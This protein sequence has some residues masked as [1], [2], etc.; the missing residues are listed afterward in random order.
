[1]LE[2]ETNGCLTETN[3]AESNNNGETKNEDDNMK[4]CKVSN[5]DDAKSDSTVKSVKDPEEV[6]VKSED[7]I[8]SDDENKVNLFPDDDVTLRTDL[9]VKVDKKVNDNSSKSKG[10][11]GA[12]VKGAK[13]SKHTDS[14]EDYED[15]ESNTEAA[16]KSVKTNQTNEIKP[17]KR[18]ARNEAKAERVRRNTKNSLASESGDKPAQSSNRVEGAKSNET[19]SRSKRI[20]KDNSVDETEEDEYD[21]DDEPRASKRV[22]LQYQPFQSPETLNII[23]PAIYKQ[24]PAKGQ[25]GKIVL[26]NKGDFLAV[27]NE[28]G[29]FFVCRTAQNVYKS[30]RKFKIQWLSD[31]KDPNVYL[32]DFYDTTDFE[33]VLTNLKMTRLDRGKFRLPPEERKR[34][35]NILERA[36]NVEKG[37]SEKPDPRNVVMD[38]VDFSI[39]GEEEE[40]EL[41]QTVPQ[42]KEVKDKPTKVKQKTEKLK[43]K[44]EVE[45]PPKPK[46]EKK[47]KEVPRDERRSTRSS[48]AAEPDVKVELKSPRRRRSEAKETRTEAPVENRFE[49][50]SEGRSSKADKS[51]R[52]A[53]LKSVSDHKR[54]KI[55]ISLI[56]N[57]KVT[58]IERD[59]MFDSKEDVTPVSSYVD[60]KV[61]IRAVNRKD[62]ELIDKLASEKR[63]SCFCV[64][65]SV[66]VTR[67]AFS[68]ALQKQDLSAL[69]ILTD[70]KYLSSMV[71]LPNVLISKG[72]GQKKHLVVCGQVNK[73]A[74]QAL[75]AL[76]TDLCPR[77]C[78]YRVLRQRAFFN[79]GL[80][81]QCLKYGMSEQNLEK[82]TEL[83]V[84][85]KSNIPILLC[86]N[87]A[88]AIKYGHRETARYLV[89]KALKSGGYGFTLLHADLLGDDTLTSTGDVNFKACSNHGIAPIHCAAINPD[90]YFLS[91]C[92]GH[93]GDLSLVDGEGWSPL[94][95]AAV[96]SGKRPL[97]YLLNHNCSTFQRD[98]RHNTP[99]HLAVSRGRIGNV[100]LILSHEANGEGTSC[101][102]K[103]NK[104]GYTPLHLACEGGHAEIVSILL[105]SGADGEKPTSSG[106]YL[107]PLMVAARG[108]HLPVVKMLIEKGVGIEFIDVYERTALLHA[109]MNGCS[110]VVSY[111]LRLGADGQAIEAFGNSGLHYACGYGW[112][113]CMKLMVESGVDLN[114]VNSAGMS[115][116]MMG[117]IKG[118]I[119]VVRQ[120]MELGGKLEDNFVESLSKSQDFE[121]IGI[122]NEMLTFLDGSLVFETLKHPIN[123]LTVDRI[124]LL[125][126]FKIDLSRLDSD[127]NNAVS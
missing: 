38:G 1:M 111:L 85:K 86:N 124:S 47:E 114:G 7:K 125:S 65:R 52:N 74:P 94:H 99:L 42:T 77:T 72:T 87:I 82:L 112:N 69:M 13:L 108:G 102:E 89:N 64:P 35:M 101:I 120:Y 46:K 127:A 90:P 45:A 91:Y 105:Q 24:P 28:L 123:Q 6:F 117:Y 118:H 10:F 27:R 83:N 56:P 44:K 67:D 109:V 80:I 29:T 116:G 8:V 92:C 62:Y 20:R 31:D 121:A 11:I 115:A 34:T 39:V 119:G 78:E 55:R 61:L 97:Q 73:I 96:C 14:T 37:I 59:L 63:I 107:T 36:I 126:D 4:P 110:A 70:N 26:F 106:D 18:S 23:S 3:A 48:K 33:C 50:R 71:D 113:D 15:S 79:S 76:M 41:I 88:T 68:Y 57:P 17:V 12:K 43:E 81:R 75:E 21:D 19:R 100:E 5:C 2:I 54:P 49:K 30:S 93:G 22:R 9:K 84:R 95:Y 25:E 122:A 32:P 104:D 58:H 53:K 66:H 60:S 103:H 16:G 51:S 40:Q 98:N